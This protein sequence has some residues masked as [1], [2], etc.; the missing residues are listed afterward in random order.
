LQQTE[1]W[2]ALAGKRL[3]TDRL[4]QFLLMLAQDFGQ[5]EPQGVRIP[6]KLTH[7]QLATAVGT[8]RVT[9]TR[10]LKDLKDQGWLRFDQRYL[11]LQVDPGGL[12]RQ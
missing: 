2:L 6:L 11:V 10:L 3:V 9:I 7:Y 5:V 8:T 1:A 12:P 4:Q